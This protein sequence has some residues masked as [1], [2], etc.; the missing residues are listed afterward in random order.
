VLLFVLFIP[1]YYYGSLS[2][3]EVKEILSDE[4]DGTFLIRDSIKDADT[5]V[6]AVK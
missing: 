1:S 6:L 2:K 4:L 5:K 3:E